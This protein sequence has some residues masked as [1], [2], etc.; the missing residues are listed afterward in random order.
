MWYTIH[1][2]RKGGSVVD[3]YIRVYIG[4]EGIGKLQAIAKLFF[5]QPGTIARLLVMSQLN[6]ECN[7]EL[8]K[9]VKE[10]LNKGKTNNEK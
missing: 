8:L 4:D 2:T 1:R 7:K 6:L 5:Q 3:K 9:K 10:Q